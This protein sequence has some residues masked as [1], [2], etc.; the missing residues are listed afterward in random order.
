MTL[1][2]HETPEQP[3]PRTAQAQAIFS[4]NECKFHVGAGGWHQIATLRRY[5]QAS[6]RLGLTS[7]PLDPGYCSNLTRGHND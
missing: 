4:P 2:S 7:L 3:S 1:A 5:L 6:W